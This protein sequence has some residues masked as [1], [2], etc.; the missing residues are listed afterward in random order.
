M[1]EERC[2]LTR[3]AVGIASDTKLNEQVHA[4]E[5]SALAY[6]FGSVE[7]EDQGKGQLDRAACRG[8]AAIRPEVRTTH[9]SFRHH[10][11]VVMAERTGV[12]VEAHVWKG[13]E[14]FAVRVG[15]RIVADGDLAG[16]FRSCDTGLEGRERRSD[17][18][19]VLSFEVVDD[20]GLTQLPNGSLS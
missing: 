19:L 16:E 3:S 6:E 2:D 14:K 17:V 20:R 13:D 15:N 8:K 18:V 1:V 7:F 4:V 9:V 11:V 5:I 10:L 12:D